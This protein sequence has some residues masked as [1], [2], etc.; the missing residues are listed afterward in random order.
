MTR[1]VWLS[2]ADS[3]F[4]VRATYSMWL[5][6]RSRG[7]HHSLTCIVALSRSRPLICL[8]LLSNNWVTREKHLSLET[9][10][11]IKSQCCIPASDQELTKMHHAICTM[12]STITKSNTVL[13]KKQLKLSPQPHA[14]CGPDIV[15]SQRRG[16]VS[17]G[18]FCTTDAANRTCG[19][20]C[21]VKNVSR[22]QSSGCAGSKQGS[23]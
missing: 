11:I 8:R 20:S 7:A 22:M 6:R 9:G 12:H 21:L 1:A 23:R 4:E 13:G 14:P 2:K 3:Q 19:W 16:L 15:R 17:S 10:E 18:P 5:A